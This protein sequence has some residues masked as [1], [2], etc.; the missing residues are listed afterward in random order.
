[1]NIKLQ[2]LRLKNFKGC[3]NFVLDI[4]GKSV[5]VYGDNGT[6]KTT[7]FDAW[8][9]ILFDKDSNHNKLGENVKT[10]GT[11]GLEHEVEAVISV[12]NKLMTLRKV[13]Y[14]KYTKKR[15]QAVAEKTGNTTD[16]YINDVPVQLKEYN[17]HILSIIDPDT[18]KLLTSP[19]YFNEQLAWKQ[20]R[21]VLI[22]LAGDVTNEEVAAAD[23]SLQKL[24]SVISDRSI[25]DHRKVIATKKATIN[26]ELEQIPHR[27]DEAVRALPNIDDFNSTEIEGEIQA[28]TAKREEKQSE[29]IR[30]KNSDPVIA[31]SYTHLTLPTKR[32]V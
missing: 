12:N 2:T 21:D 22:N 4:N 32:I 28:I 11:S 18:F 10:V 23:P 7:I 3:R 30:L 19:L 24:L 1:M 9:W 27:T 15:G 20:R 8:L 5:N 14:E 25:D 13:Y 31:V 6:F 29:L 26:K 16:Y 17:E